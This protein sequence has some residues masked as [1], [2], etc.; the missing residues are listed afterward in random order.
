MALL[1]LLNKGSSKSLSSKWSISVFTGKKKNK[2][3]KFATSDAG[4]CD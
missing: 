2:Y 3:R 1:D 4:V